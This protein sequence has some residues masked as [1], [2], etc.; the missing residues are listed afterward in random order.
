MSITAFIEFLQPPISLVV[1]GAGNDAV[2]MLQIADT[3][4]WDVRI[5]DGRNTHARPERFVAACQIL[6][7]KPEAVVGSAANGR[8]NGFCH[9][10]TQLQL[11]SVDAKGIVANPEPIHWDAW[12]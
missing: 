11:R 9:D 2:P 8:Q 12:A 6:V 3:L 1:V 5:V 10:D 7:A 4:G